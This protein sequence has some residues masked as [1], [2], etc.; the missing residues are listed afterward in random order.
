MGSPAEGERFFDERWPEARAVSDTERVLYAGFG[1]ERGRFG[2][3]LGPRAVWAG[4]RAAL[5]G[6]GV[7]RPVGDPMMMPG[8]FLVHDETVIWQ[9]VHD[10]AG[11]PARFDE[12]TSA[13]AARPR[14]EQVAG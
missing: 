7:G 10:H 9:H 5:R 4:V 3:L 12:V 13:L 6:H 14:T 8:W 1:L 2:Q 11:A